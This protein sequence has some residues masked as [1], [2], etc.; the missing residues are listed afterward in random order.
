MNAR[1]F[2]DPIQPVI[3]PKQLLQC[4]AD[5]PEFAAAT[6]SI[7]AIQ[8][9]SFTSAPVVRCAQEAALTGGLG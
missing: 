1:S 9:G 6:A 3:A 4:A 7:A 5:W 2:V 8:N